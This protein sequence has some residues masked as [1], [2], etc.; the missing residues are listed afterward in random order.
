M[1]TPTPPPF[2][3]ALLLQLAELDNGALLPSD[4]APLV[5][6]HDTAVETARWLA[7]LAV[8][9]RRGPAQSPAEAR[10]EIE[11]LLMTDADTRPT[12]PEGTTR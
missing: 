9:G 2:R 7:K 12:D 11:R 6:D 4:L 5:A 1:T 8:M 10:A 3:L